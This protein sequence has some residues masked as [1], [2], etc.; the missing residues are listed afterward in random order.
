MDFAD[1]YGAGRGRRWAAA[2]G[3]ALGLIVAV[4]LPHLAMAPLV[5][6]LLL[7]R[8]G[9]RRAG[10]LAGVAGFLA[11][12]ALTL[13]PFLLAGALGDL[14]FALLDYSPGYIGSTFNDLLHDGW[15][16][17]IRWL[18]FFPG[19]SLLIAGLLLAAV[20]WRDEQLRPL[21]RI[22][23]AW[24]ALGWI[25][26]RSSGRDYAHYFV[27]VTPPLALLVGAG[28]AV[29]GRLAP[30]LRVAIPAFVLCVLSAQ[31]AVD[32]WRRAL[33]VPAHRR[34]MGTDQAQLAGLD[35]AARLVGRITRPR[36]RVYVVSSAG[37]GGQLLYWLADRRPAH[38]L[39]FPGE[40]APSRL[41]E[42]ARDLAQH[43]PAALV[44]IAGTSIEPY[45][46]ALASGG[47]SEVGHYGDDPITEVRVFARP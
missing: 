34:W 18:V 37:R 12:V 23:V 22:A 7:R 17:R 30:A 42:V 26:A 25:F 36:D 15:E 24:L 10:V 28:L 32:G 38:R 6:A 1:R 8:P 47:L 20:A 21:V 44:L 9:R 35:E 43:P 46:G 11:V 41:D 29:A 5:L 39:M 19:L 13:L 45:R 31:L 4:K 27:V 2:A 14:R 40:M 3:A 33:D 16:R